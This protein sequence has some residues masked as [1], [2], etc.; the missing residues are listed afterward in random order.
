M[1]S[2]LHHPGALHIARLG[3]G[4]SPCSSESGRIFVVKPLSLSLFFIKL[5]ASC[6]V[7]KKKKK[8][9]LDEV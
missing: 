4:V 7:L 8:I 3:G 5:V 9:S 1:T 2:G 6:G